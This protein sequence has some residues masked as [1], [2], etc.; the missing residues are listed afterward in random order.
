MVSV[1]QAKGSGSGVG[2][3]CAARPRASGGGDTAE[4][5]GARIHGIPERQIGAAIVLTI[6]KSDEALLGTALVG[7]RLLCQSNWA[8]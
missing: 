2:V 1:V 8:G 3:E 5:Y 4:V 7:A 6:P